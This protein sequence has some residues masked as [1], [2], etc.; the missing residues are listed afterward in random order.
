MESTRRS[1]DNSSAAIPV[2]EATRRDAPR[3]DATDGEDPCEGD[4][5]VRVRILCLVVVTAG[6]VTGCG[7]NAAPTPRQG[8]GQAVAIRTAKVSRIAIQRQVELAGTLASSDQVRV[9][10]EVAGIVREVAVELGS[11]VRAGDVIVRLD[12]RELALAVDRAESAL[13]QVEAQLGTD[14]AQSP[15]TLAD[16]QIAA[17]QQAAATRD[18]ALAVFNRAQELHG[19]GLV[20]QADRDGAQTRLKVAEATYNSTVNN[21]RSLKAS[22]QDR[23]AAF[24]LARKKLNDAVIRAPIDGAIAERLVQPGE[25]IRENTPVVTIVKVHPLRLRTAVQ[26]RFAGV[27][28]SGQ[29]VAF[30][31][32]AFPDRSFA[33]KVA[34]VGPA[35]DQATRTFPIEALVDNTSGE[36]KPGFFAK[37]SVG[38]R[39]DD[40]IAAVPENAISTMA[41]VTTV[42]VVD[43]GTAR[44]Q[45][46]T[47]GQR[48]GELVE[49]ATG[50]TGTETVA[51]SNLNLLATGTAVRDTGPPA[52]PATAGATS[53]T[54][55]RG[56]DAPRGTP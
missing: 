41:G 31:V 52:A 2:R 28:K 53:A 35:V 51:S 23:R 37:A 46:I 8:G 4:D 14:R 17:V 39:L 29:V 47:V 34:Y 32:E 49:V 1:C 26:E 48:V 22:L 54:Q 50:L 55:E 19:R 43:N 15:A 38:T 16:D 18:D 24:D 12:A 27:I 44:Q 36:L 21:V 45:P 40:D 6:I 9:S 7:R 13:R 11:R 30:S 56:A 5:N 33:G 25:Y 10:G 20:S 3:P 42:F